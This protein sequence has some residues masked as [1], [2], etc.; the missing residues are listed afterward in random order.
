VLVA[1]FRRCVLGKYEV[2]YFQCEQC[3]SLQTEP[4]YWLDEA[5]RENNLS[6]LDTGS[7]QRNLQNLAACWSIA[8]LLD[9]RNVVDVGGG[10]GLLCR[11]LRDYEINCYVHD[12]YAKPNY[13]QG[14][15]HPDFVTPDLIVAFE[16]LEHYPRPHDDLEVLFGQRP[17][18]IVATTGLYQDQTED[19]WYLAPES[20]QHVFFYSCQAL[21]EVARRHGYDL[22]ISGGYLLFLRSGTF[23]GV[24][25]AL[26]RL[27]L[28]SK[29]RRWTKALLVTRSA[30]GVWKDHT[31]QVE[32]AKS[33]VRG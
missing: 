17:K 1:R 16:V 23:G 28:K 2:A 19:W 33:G 6:N 11:L 20:G 10:D 3:R 31:Q 9:L 27:M 26:A 14:F 7:A 32:K 18:A 15:E 5:Y 21:H 12:R 13:A 4:P 22:L 24:R 29:A 8:K 30:A 25:R